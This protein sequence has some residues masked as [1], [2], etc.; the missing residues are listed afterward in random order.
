MSDTTNT[1][2]VSINSGQTS[3]GGDV[4]GRD[5]II[6]APDPL[7]QYLHQL[8]P[9]PS[10][11]VGRGAEQQDLLNMIERGALIT[12]LRGMGGIGKTALGLVPSIEGALSRRAVLPGFSR[13]GR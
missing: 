10:D 6:Q 12:G 4:I 9:A 2:G 8:P 5:Q 1:S 7:A 11:F 13:R 3:I